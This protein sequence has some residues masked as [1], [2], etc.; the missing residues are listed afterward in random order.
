MIGI[1]DIDWF[2]PV[3]TVCH[4][5][6]LICMALLKIRRN[7]IVIMAL[8]G[9]LVLAALYIGSQSAQSNFLRSEIAGSYRGRE[10]V[11]YVISEEGD[12][13]AFYSE[14][15]EYVRTGTIN[16]QTKDG[17]SVCQFTNKHS[18]KTYDIKVDGGKA[19]YLVR[20]LETDTLIAVD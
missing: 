20:G 3:A 4:T 13:V 8:F 10:G 5:A 19:L 18:G 16:C 14:Q 6:L 12:V 17:A 9:Y 7:N 2:F 15:R 11:S 1:G